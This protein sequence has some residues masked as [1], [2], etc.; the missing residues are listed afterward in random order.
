MTTLC[1]QFI[2]FLGYFHILRNLAPS[3]GTGGLNVVNTKEQS[4]EEQR[5][6]KARGLCNC[7]F[8]HRLRQPGS[9]RKDFMHIILLTT[10]GSASQFYPPL[11]ISAKDVSWSV[12]KVTLGQLQSMCPYKIPRK[13]R[14]IFLLCWWCPSSPTPGALFEFRSFWIVGNYAR[15]SQFSK[16]I[17]GWKQKFEGQTEQ[18]DRFG[19]SLGFFNDWLVD[20]GDSIHHFPNAPWV[21]FPDHSFTVLQKKKCV[22]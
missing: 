2:Y 14:N 15:M 16:R 18:S 10:E 4:I 9:N 13:R 3:W 8:E 17:H 1:F 7:L 20:L 19:V 22:K 6:W 11:Y 21:S 5:K 12:L